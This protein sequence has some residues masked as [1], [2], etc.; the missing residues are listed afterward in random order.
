MHAQ[1]DRYPSTP[2]ALRRNSA[3]HTAHPRPSDRDFYS[4]LCLVAGPLAAALGRLAFNGVGPVLIL[5][6]LAAIVIGAALPPSRTRIIVALI[7]ISLGLWPL[8]VAIPLA[9]LT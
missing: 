6:G 8:T 1:P 3:T 9:W 2:I 7:G 4:T 5:A